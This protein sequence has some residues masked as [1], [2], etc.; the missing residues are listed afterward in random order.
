M[1]ERTTADETMTRSELASYLA[2][3]GDEFERGGED[4]NVAVGNKTV[5]LAPPESINVSVD[6]VERSS[7]LRGNRETIT[8]ELNWKP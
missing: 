5:D 6:V 3:L 2:S 8:I 1:A 7:M 4:I